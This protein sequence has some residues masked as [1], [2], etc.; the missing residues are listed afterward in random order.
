MSLTNQDIN[1][2][3]RQDSGNINVED[4]FR[5]I[6]SGGKR[7]RVSPYSAQL[8]ILTT[9]ASKK[10]T[11]TI[12]PESTRS[13]RVSWNSEVDNGAYFARRWQL[14]LPQ[15]PLVITDTS[16]DPRYAIQTKGFAVQYRP[17]R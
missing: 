16:K 2:M 8:P 3:V 6:V 7:E 5:F 10:F 13:S 4:S 17:L 9:P 15:P 12:F 1:D 14:G 11:D